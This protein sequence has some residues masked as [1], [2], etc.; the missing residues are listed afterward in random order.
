MK[1]LYYGIKD[2]I[3]VSIDDVCSGKKCN[4]ICP[5]CGE[6]L[7]AKKGEINIHHFAH[8][9][10]KECEYGYETSLHLLAKDIIKN[11]N[12]FV[13]PKDTL[14]IEYY[15][16][17]NYGGKNYEGLE[18][19]HSVN[20]DNVELEL[21]FD[22]MKPDIVITS[23]GK[24][25]FIEIFV[26]H[27]IDEEKRKKIIEKNIDTIEIDLSCIDKG[28]ESDILK[29]ILLNDDERKYWI[30]NGKI[31]SIIN[32]VKECAIPTVT[33][34][35]AWHTEY[36]PKHSK[37]YYGKSYANVANDCMGCEYFLGVTPQE[38]LDI[39]QKV[40]CIGA[41]NNKPFR[42]VSNPNYSICPWCHSKLNLITGYFGAFYRCSNRHCN[43]KKN[44]YYRRG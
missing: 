7:I 4:C 6:P 10:Q 21:P 43:F 11:S 27:K 8:V 13:L 36:C 24:K 31:E 29:D 44:I 17:G 28:I 37:E 16:P 15:Q 1:R 18:E 42:E 3:I 2:G 9:S 26:T 19:A 35:F 33:H 12:Y 5:S 20:I 40:F 39:K 30:Y 32:R 41:E 23:G 14:K 22:N 25:Y 34:G 38:S